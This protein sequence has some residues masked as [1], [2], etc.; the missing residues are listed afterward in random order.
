MQQLF[1]LVELYLGWVRECSIIPHTGDTDM[2]IFSEEH[3]EALLRAILTS[4][5]FKIYWV[6]GRL[7]NSFELSVFVDEF[8][9]D[10]F[11]LYKSKENASINGMRSWVKQRIRWNYPKLSGEICAAELHGKL[12][13]VLCDYQKIIESDYGIEGWK[14]DFD[15]ENY[16]WD[17]DV[18]NQEDM[19]IYSDSEW[20][21]VYHIG[22]DINK[23]EEWINSIN[24]TI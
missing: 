13:H 6:L 18:K 7:K 24:K 23:V 4:K 8:K 19:E 2:G 14:K 15:T 12:F 17:R 22:F 1:F 10:L 20:P 3:S 9:I 21:D 5:V 11:Y 16:V